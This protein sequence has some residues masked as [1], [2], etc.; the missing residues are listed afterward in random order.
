MSD[1]ASP[2]RDPLDD[3]DLEEIVRSPGENTGRNVAQF[4]LLAMS[5]AGVT[6]ISLRQD[7]L[8]T[9]VHP[10]DG[11][12]SASEWKPIPYS[13][14]SLRDVFNG[15]VTTCNSEGGKEHEFWFS[16]NNKSLVGHIDESGADEIQLSVDLDKKSLPTE[17]TTP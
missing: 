17:R 13:F 2:I 15:W 6:R 3:P 10:G 8:L 1:E 11:N 9:R 4:L 5:R 7:H 16:L 12:N 14:A